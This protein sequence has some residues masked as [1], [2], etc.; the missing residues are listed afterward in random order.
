MPVG[1]RG[2]VDE[3]HRRTER[4]FERGE[5]SARRLR[6]R[7]WDLAGGSNEACRDHSCL[8]HKRVTGYANSSSSALS[9]ITPSLPG[10]GLRTRVDLL[11]LLAA[12]ER[13]LFGQFEVWAVE[14]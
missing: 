2:I 5:S 14:H 13:D 7:W 12:S 11:R 10:A 1:A 9:A 3:D 4:R 6:R 8:R